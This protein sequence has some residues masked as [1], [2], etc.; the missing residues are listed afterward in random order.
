MIKHFSKEW[1]D[2]ICL[3]TGMPD[4]ATQD[5]MKTAE[6]L[7]SG[8]VEILQYQYE[9]LIN[10]STEIS[11]AA[12]MQSMVKKDPAFGQKIMMVYLMAAKHTKEMYIDKGMTLNVFYDTMKSF[13][14]FEQ[15]YKFE[16]GVWGFDKPSWAVNHLRMNLYRLGRLV[17]EQ[18]KFPFDYS[19]LQVGTLK[20]GDNVLMVHIPANEKL[21]LGLC[22]ESYNIADMF[23]K[24]HFNFISKAF[25]CSSWLLYKGLE[26]VLQPQ[27]NILK[28]QN[29]YEIINETFNNDEPLKWIFGK[30]YESLDDYPLST[31]LQKGVIE[32]LKNNGELGVSFGVRKY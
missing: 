24:K 1:I 23:S 7:S 32:Y 8:E 6:Y 29:E 26:N 21:E 25:C 16:H 22:H 27:S 10:S 14:V 30:T 28:F 13:A 18:G 5:I 2:E 15:N 3:K 17:F 9:R 4:E 20:K 19:S 12:D 11:A 31:S